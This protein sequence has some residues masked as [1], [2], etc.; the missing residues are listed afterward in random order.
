MQPSNFGYAPS[1]VQISV[2]G[3]MEDGEQE[4]RK[5]RTVTTVK[6]F[7]YSFARYCT[8]QHDPVL[9]VDLKS[10]NFSF[11]SVPLCLYGHVDL[12]LEEKPALITAHVPSE[13]L[14]KTFEITIKTLGSFPWREDSSSVSL[15]IFM[16][17]QAS[18]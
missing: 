5:G 6:V 4:K 11:F 7:S 13:T 18:P 15:H 3:H 1:D 8:A 16:R 2:L 10:L 9:L 14:Y 17:T 12:S